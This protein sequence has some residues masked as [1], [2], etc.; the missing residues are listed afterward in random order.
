MDPSAYFLR[1]AASFV[2]GRA[3]RGDL[4]ELTDEQRDAPL[5]DLSD[6]Q[7]RSIFEAGVVAGL[8]LHKFKQT[9]GLARVRRVF[10]ALRALAPAELLDV[11][12]GR[13]TF[14]WPLLHEFPALAITAIDQD[15]RRAGDLEC[16]RVGGV[17]RLKTAQ[18]DVTNLEF[19]DGEFDVIT[20]LEVLE[21]IPA[22]LQAVAEVVRVARRFVVLSVPSKPDDN[23]EHIHLFDESRI[24]ELFA[25]ANVHRLRVDYVLNH[26]V[27]VANVSAQAAS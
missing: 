14:L 16:V 19:D 24:R 25:A 15:E 26:I 20:V 21:H 10:G 13:G 9:M 2:R 23:P 5:A 7:L 18:M 1:T 3:L 27:V 6:D 11:G 22:A 8:K 17:D 12:S 4:I